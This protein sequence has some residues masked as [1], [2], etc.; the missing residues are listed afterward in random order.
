MYFIFTDANFRTRLSALLDLYTTLSGA[1]KVLQDLQMLPWERQKSYDSMLDDLKLKRDS[2]P[3]S[4][5]PKARLDAADIRDVLAQGDEEDV[6]E[7]WPNLSRHKLS[8]AQ[9]SLT[10]IIV[11]LMTCE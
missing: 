7:R 2:L 1:S 10:S 9:V 4:R 6:Q 8:S 11:F 3:R 5:N